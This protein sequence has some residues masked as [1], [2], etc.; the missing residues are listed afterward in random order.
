LIDLD[1]QSDSSRGLN[2]HVSLLN[3]SIFQV[4]LRDNLIFLKFLIF[5]R[6]KKILKYKDRNE[7]NKN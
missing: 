2:I 6:D 3:E 7:E 1:P 5:I 4:L